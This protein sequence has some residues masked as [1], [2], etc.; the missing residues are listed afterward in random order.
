MRKGMCGVGIQLSSAEKGGEVELIVSRIMEGGAAEQ[1]LAINDV[2]EMVDGKD[3]RGIPTFF[4]VQQILG[5]AQTPVTLDIR[6]GAE[7]KRVVILRQPCSLPNSGVKS[8]R[9]QMA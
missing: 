3:V 4:V 2:I 7:S 5:P 8:T 6:R 1:Q 9:K